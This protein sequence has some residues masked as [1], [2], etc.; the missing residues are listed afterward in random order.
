[1]ASDP[2]GGELVELDHAEPVPDM[3]ADDLLVALASWTPRVSTRPTH[4][5][6]H[7]PTIDTI[8]SVKIGRRVVIP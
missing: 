3:V 6:V 1:M 4:P 8:P 7:A 5:S 2:G